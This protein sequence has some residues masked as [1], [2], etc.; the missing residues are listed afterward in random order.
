VKPLE[1]RDKVAAPPKTV[2]RRRRRVSPEGDEGGAS[3]EVE[4]MGEKVEGLAPGIDRATLRKL[5]SGE[6]PRDARIDL[7][8]HD[9][10]GARRRV[11]EALSD[12]RE[13][14]GRCL[15]VIHGRGNRSEGGPVLKDGLLEWLAEPPVGD[16]VM[17]FCSALGRDGGV[18]ATYVLLRKKD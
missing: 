11:H 7:H 18:G 17:A 4:R 1:D 9:A 6:V 15:L 16:W 3:F 13:R 8:G 5:R 14:G 2:R 10:A 12:L